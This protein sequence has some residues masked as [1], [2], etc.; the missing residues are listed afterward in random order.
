MAVY[1]LI[2]NDKILKTM[3]LRKIIIIGILSN[4]GEDTLAIFRNMTIYFKLSSSTASMSISKNLGS[5]SI[6]RFQ[7]GMNVTSNGLSKRV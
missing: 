5:A 7:F 2:H 1:W 6:T 4:K 3:R